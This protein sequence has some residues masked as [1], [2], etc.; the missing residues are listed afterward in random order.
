MVTDS[1]RVRARVCAVYH[2]TSYVYMCLLSHSVV[3]DS[4]TSWT[5]AY[6]GSSVFGIFQARILE[7]VAVSYSNV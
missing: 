5:V 1:S 7:W 4:V 2:G 3:L 6:S